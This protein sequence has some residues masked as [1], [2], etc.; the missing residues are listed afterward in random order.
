M[1]RWASPAGP[2]RA[3]LVLAAALAL[4]A[5]SGCAEETPGGLR[6]VEAD[7]VRIQD[8]GGP[9]AAATGIGCAET[10]TEALTNARATAQYNLRTVLGSGKYKVD[11]RIL[12][13]VPGNKRYCVE[14]EARVIR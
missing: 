1:P 5:L 14:V 10:D 6:Y 12:R 2:V 9:H 3:G 4:S 11:F 7:Q 13:E 8:P